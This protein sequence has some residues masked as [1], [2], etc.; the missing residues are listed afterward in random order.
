MRELRSEKL[1]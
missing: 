1:L